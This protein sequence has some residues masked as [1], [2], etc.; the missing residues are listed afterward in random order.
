ML[1]IWSRDPPILG[2]T[3]P[4]NS[5]EW[6]VPYLYTD[7]SCFVC[8]E[9]YRG[10]SLTRK[11]NP[12]GPY[13]KGP[14]GVGVF[15]LARYTCTD[16]PSRFPALIHLPLRLALVRRAGVPRPLENAHPPRTPLWPQ[17]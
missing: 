8:S 17:A 13:A 3:K 12:L 1:Q 14:R 9:L 5:T 16:A 15:V 10:T 4:S 2:G 6:L 11:C 7:A